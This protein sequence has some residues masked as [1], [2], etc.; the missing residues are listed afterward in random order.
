MR[1][2]VLPLVLL[3]GCTSPLGGLNTNLA[4]EQ[5]VEVGLGGTRGSLTVKEAQTVTQVQQQ[6]IAVLAEKP[7]DVAVDQSISPKFVA[8]Q[9][10]YDKPQ[11]VENITVNQIN[12]WFVVLLLLGWLLPSPGTIASGTRDLML[13]LRQKKAPKDE[14]KGPG[15]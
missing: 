2:F 3:M 1:A 6:K 13:S 7:K 11:K 12:P 8:K 4:L 5:P 14:P 15:V 10:T 9:V